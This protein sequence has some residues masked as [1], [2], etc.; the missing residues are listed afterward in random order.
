ML[1]GKATDYTESAAIIKDVIDRDTGTTFF[2]CPSLETSEYNYRND[3]KIFRKTGSF[4][5][6]GPLQEHISCILQTH[7]DQ[8]AVFP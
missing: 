2:G 3:A 4:P 1:S 7:I 8:C 6:P 5:L